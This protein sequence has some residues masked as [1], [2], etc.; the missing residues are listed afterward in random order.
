MTA[1][2]VIKERLESIKEKLLDP[3]NTDGLEEEF[4]SLLKLL[5]SAEPDQRKVIAKDFEEVKGLL[6]RNL[7][8]ISGG[9]KPLLEGDR[10]EFF[11]RRV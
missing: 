4:L 8:I 9:L 10:G 3:F 7:E 6:V 2:E 11:S 5:E 1:K